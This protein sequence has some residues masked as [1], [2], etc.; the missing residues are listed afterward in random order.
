MT[1]TAPGDEIVG[2][3]GVVK[4]TMPTLFPAVVVVMMPGAT[5]PLLA[6][7]ENAEVAEKSRLA[8]R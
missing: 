5:V 8:D 6:R 3:R 4:P 1:D 7:A 2:R